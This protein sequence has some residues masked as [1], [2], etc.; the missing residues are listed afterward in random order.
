[1]I[2]ITLIP[3]NEKYN[4]PIYHKES[5]DRHHHELLYEFCTIVGVNYDRENVY[6][7]LIAENFI[8]IV[9]S[10]NPLL[11]V[12]TFL[13]N[14]LSL[15]QQDYLKKLRVFYE[16]FEY[17][18]FFTYLNDNINISKVDGLDIS[19][20]LDLFYKELDNYYKK[21]EGRK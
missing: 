17:I 4:L 16:K 12:S 13:P 6:N 14:E 3:N 21:G 7:S 5:N 20:V 1:M 19:M 10:D 2:S 9:T 11:S 18:D 8:I 15:E